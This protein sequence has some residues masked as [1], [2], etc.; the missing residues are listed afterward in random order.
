MGEPNWLSINPTPSV[1]KG[2]ATL[3]ANSTEGASISRYRLSAVSVSGGQTLTLAGA[4]DGS[5]TYIELYVTGDI[6]VSGTSQ[7]ILGDGVRAKIYFRG[8]VD[9][10]GKGVLNPGNQ[11]ES[12]LLYGVQPLAGT[13]PQV[14]L[15]GNGQIT[16]AVYAPDHTVTVNGGG[17]SGHVFGSVVGKTVSMN[18]VTNLHY[19]EALGSSG[20]INNYQIVSW[21]EDTR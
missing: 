9:I 6:S 20:T 14:T 17:N 21:V 19:D 16:A 15:D 3:N 13:N 18:G 2:S 7:I 4:P 11:P 8:N 1:V 10:G 5:P 12:L